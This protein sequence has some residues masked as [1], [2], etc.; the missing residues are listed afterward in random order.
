MVELKSV[1]LYE[2]ENIVVHGRTIESRDPAYLVWSGS[3]IEMN[4]KASELQI[5]I[6][7]EYDYQE[8]WIAI[9]INGEIISRRMISKEKEW[10]TIFRNINPENIV[11]VKIINE[12]QAMNLDSHHCIKVY[13]VKLD[14][15]IFPVEKKDLKIEFIGDSVTS[16]EG[17]IGAKKE[18]DWISMFFSHTRSYPYLVSKKL[19]ADYKIVSQSGWGAFHSWDNQPKCA[20]PLY[21]EEI[22]SLVDGDYFKEL[23]FKN[24]YDFSKW[25]PDFI[26]I[27]L[28]TND[29]MAFNNDAYTDPLTG[30]VHK[31]KK[32]GESYDKEDLEKV[33]LAMLS[34]LEK[35]RKNNEN[36]VIIWAFGILGE[37][38]A[39]AIKGALEE[40]NDD[41][42][43]YLSL[44]ELTEKEKGSRMH[45]GLKAHKKMAKI[46]S[47]FIKD[48][49]KNN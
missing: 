24:K 39:P 32:N 29:D 4:V 8:N 15:E 22:C 1:K 9:E 5:L 2:N 45:P 10:I 46:I 35:V 40:F 44:P 21:Y 43:F 12:V 26:V 31:L 33:R 19:D 36:A 37:G 6:E 30:E 13:E 47:K 27:N 23:G 25:Q 7:G 17:T 34:F 28:G 20:V 11:N 3:S 14:G 18:M 41:K 48:Y 49:R 38:M 16:A 42:A